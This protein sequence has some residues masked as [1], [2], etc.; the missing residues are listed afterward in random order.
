M[1][2]VRWR[3]MDRKGEMERVRWR[4]S[5]RGRDGE[6]ERGGEREVERGRDGERKRERERAPCCQIT[7]TVP[8]LMIA[9][10]FALDFEASPTLAYRKWIVLQYMVCE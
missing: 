4:E 10:L 6:R 3:E 8:P 9:P 2:R 1:E 7:K 5:E